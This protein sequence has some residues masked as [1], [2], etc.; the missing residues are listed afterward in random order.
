MVALW[1]VLWYLTG[2]AIHVWL[3]LEE[4]DYTTRSITTTL[5]AGVSGP[6][7]YLIGRGAQQMMMYRR[8]EDRDQ[9]HVEFVRSMLSLNKTTNTTLIKM[10]SLPMTQN[11][12]YSYWSNPFDSTVLIRTR[13]KT[14]RRI[15]DG[16]TP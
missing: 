12:D 10:G 6:F 16:D 1:F 11:Y 13:N 3:E 15:Q 7:T 14:I 2:I 5:I 9:H 4:W 8:K